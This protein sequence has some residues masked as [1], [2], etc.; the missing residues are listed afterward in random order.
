MPKALHKKLKKQ[1][2]EKGLKGKRAKKYTYGT[3]SKIK[4]R[5]G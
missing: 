1:A 4:K 3:M 5:G 2:K